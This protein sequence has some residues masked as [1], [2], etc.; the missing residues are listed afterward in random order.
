MK[1]VEKLDR[2]TSSTLRAHRAGTNTRRSRAKPVFFRR[3]GG[4]RCAVLWLDDSVSRCLATTD[5]GVT[6]LEMV[7]RLKKG[8]RWDQHGVSVSAL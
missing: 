6:A 3:R 4:D 2:L 5:S 8:A 7:P 1:L